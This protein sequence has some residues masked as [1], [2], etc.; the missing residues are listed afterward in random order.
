MGA[1]T[2]GS[3]V[4]TR[5]TIAAALL[6]FLCATLLA[7]QR[8]APEKQS[9]PVVFRSEVTYVEVDATVLDANGKPVTDLGQDDF[10]VVEDGKP[11]EVAAFSFVNIPVEHDAGTA[12]PGRDVEPDVRTNEGSEGRIYF[13]VLD[14]L[15]IA[16]DHN[17]RTRTVA[18]QFVEQHFGDNDV[19]SVIYTSGR[20]R[21]GQDL[22][23]S[24][25]AIL[26]AID[27]FMGDKIDTETAKGMVD[28]AQYR[29]VKRTTTTIRQ[30]AE[31][32]GRVHGRRKA[33]L[34]VSSG[35]TYDITAIM[36]SQDLASGASKFG[37]DANLDM[38]D[39]MAAATRANVRIYPV[40][41]RGVDFDMSQGGGAERTRML[42]VN[43]NRAFAANTGGFPVVG[44]NDFSQGFTR[45][46][47]ENS[48]YYLLGYNAA[49]P[50]RDGKFRKV[51][52]RVKRPD[53][54]VIARGGYYEPRGN[55]PREPQADRSGMLPAVADA[56]ASPLP[57]GTVPL[58]VVAS[59]FKG[60]ADAARVAVTTEIDVSRLD[61]VQANQRFNEQFE[62]SYMAT[63]ARGKV[64]AGKRHTV[65][66]AMTPQTF[67]RVKARRFRVLSQMD[68]PP[69]RYQ[70]RV[71]AG[72]AAGKAGSVFYDLA[73]PDFTKG[74]ISMSGVALTSGR[75]GDAPT[76][77]PQNALAGV[78]PGPATA[79]REFAPGD[80]IALFAEFY[81]R[82]TKTRHDVEMRAELQAGDGRVIRQ[83]ASTQSSTDVDAS[84]GGLGFAARLPLEGVPAGRYVVHVSGT[85]ADGDRPTVSHDIPIRIR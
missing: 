35:I 49:N 22:T 11:Q 56:I 41:P 39:A 17:T 77:A 21:A 74:A 55:A 10:E 14:D 44:T 26:A 85:V 52:V 78:M 67:A 59:P 20:A 51:S 38:A 2:K 46:V 45:I 29:D 23:S 25:H 13:I 40:D 62:F 50:R 33:M 18:R 76:I 75:A 82:A 80:T 3:N 72:N 16:T 4:K 65:T 43:S 69:G 48:S 34:F 68:L 66:L 19:A 15:H 63:D 57:A 47:E 24:R 58:R 1:R 8:Q 9:P 73:V 5:A 60:T 64:F 53:V 42:G 30:I 70:L 7:Q 31:F 81:E 28:D 27:A 36:P 61:L 32:A 54:R 12:S 71:A 6:P 37:S 84:R 83:T 79:E